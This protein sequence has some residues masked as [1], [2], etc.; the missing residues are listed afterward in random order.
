MFLSVSSV[1]TADI[2]LNQEGKKKATIIEGIPNIF[3]YKKILKHFKKTFSCNGAIKI[4]E[5]VKGGEKAEK[6]EFIKLSGDHR[7][8]VAEFLYEEGIA[9]HEEIRVHGV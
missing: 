5:S 2:S 6:E 7:K 8:E 9:E 4:D 1:I 3:D